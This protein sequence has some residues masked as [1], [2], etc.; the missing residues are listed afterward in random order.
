VP[1]SEIVIAL[2]FA[3]VD[4]LAAKFLVSITVEE[5]RWRV[6]AKFFLMKGF[7][8]LDFCLIR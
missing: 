3:A 8:D 4:I 7:V 5:E 1:S 6:A 2:A